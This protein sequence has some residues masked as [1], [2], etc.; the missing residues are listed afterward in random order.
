MSK[1]F[2]DTELFDDSWFMNLSKDAKLLWLYLITKCDHAGIIDINKKLVEVQAGIKSYETV[3]KQLG[4]R[5]IHVR[6][7]YYFIP[8]YIE[9]Q[10]PDFPRSNVRQQQSAIKIL[11]KF[12]LFIDGK[13]TVS[14]DLT[15]SYEHEHDNDTVNDIPEFT[16]FLEYAISK[17]P[18]VDRAAL[19]LKYESWIEN[20]WHDGHNNPIKNWK[21]KLLNTLPFIKTTK[22]DESEE[23]ARKAIREAQH[24]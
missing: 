18:D 1:R 11:E 5:L 23:A 21:I 8:K 22:Y 24:G 20:K 16:V 9:F 15:K 4:N 12:G 10:Y 3:S 6:D 7:N 13:L 2:I 14:K 19:K 17:I